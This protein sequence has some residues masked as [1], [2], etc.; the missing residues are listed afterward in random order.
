MEKL[1]ATCNALSKLIILQ[2]TIYA[3]SCT[4]GFISWLLAFTNNASI[5]EGIVGEY[6][7]GHILRWTAQFPPW[8][9]LMLLSAVLSLYAT[10][11]LWCSRKKGAYLGTTSFLIGFVTNMLFARNLLVH[12]LIGILIGWALLAP[13]AVAWKNLKVKNHSKKATSP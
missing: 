8:G 3:V 13:L 1:C 11:L 6:F 2:F 7:H 12:S 10:Y 5:L 9:V 4:L